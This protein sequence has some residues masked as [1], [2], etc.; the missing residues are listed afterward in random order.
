MMAMMMT[1]RVYNTRLAE[2]CRQL[3]RMQRYKS[4]Q[5]DFIPSQ[6][7]ADN[8]V[9][10]SLETADN[11][12]YTFRIGEN[13]PFTQPTLSI[14]S[15]PHQAWVRLPSPRFK[16]MLKCVSGLDCLCCY[17]YLCPGNWRPSVTLN[18]VVRQMTD[19]RRFKY[20]IIIK[21]LLKQIRDKYLHNDDIDL[22][23]WLV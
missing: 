16:K 21:L 7:Q 20:L 8:D 13:Y 19:F 18:Q 14:N 15:I 22:D 4:I 9:L 3:M 5:I 11:V 12:T 6:G 1:E 10:F 23:T 17:S 2:E